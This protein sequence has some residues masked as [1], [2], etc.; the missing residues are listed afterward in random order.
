MEARGWKLIGWKLERQG[1]CKRPT[2]RTERRRRN[3]RIHSGGRYSAPPKK[4]DIFDPASSLVAY[5]FIA[6][7]AAPG[8]APSKMPWYF[9]LSSFSFF[10]LAIPFRKSHHRRLLLWI[11]PPSYLVL[12]KG[13]TRRRTRVQSHFHFFTDLLRIHLSWLCSQ[14]LGPNAMSKGVE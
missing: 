14:I 4:F 6:A 2:W 1:A 7:A 9:L 13:E 11:S 5:L 8:R 10:L 12:S 3:F